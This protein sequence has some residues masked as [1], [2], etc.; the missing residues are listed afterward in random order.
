MTVCS[1]GYDLSAI[2]E[3]LKSSFEEWLEK[4]E[5]V[6]ENRRKR[7]AEPD[8]LF[9][10][11][12]QEVFGITDPDIS[13]MDVVQAMT[14]PNPEASIKSSGVQKALASCK[15]QTRRK[16]AITQLSFTPGLGICPEEIP[17][18]SR[19]FCHHLK[20]VQ[21]ESRTQAEYHC[22]KSLEGK[23]LEFGNSSLRADLE[24]LVSKGKGINR[25]KYLKY[26]QNRL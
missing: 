26:F 24:E 15:S 13:I 4:N 6:K 5:F 23:V 21:F 3:E 9:Q 11:F 17:V 10:K 16:R 1:Q 25:N 22:E 12:S 7:N 2:D 8:K 20:P 18:K 19:F 14:S